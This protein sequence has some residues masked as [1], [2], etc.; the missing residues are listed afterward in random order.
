MDAANLNQDVRSSFIVY[1]KRSGKIVLIY[2]PVGDYSSEAVES[3]AIDR[4]A[5]QGHNVEHLAVLKV[6]G[7]FEGGEPQRVD[8][9]KNML[10]PDPR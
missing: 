5:W 8:V 1:E 2:S 6:E 10:V 4:A 3:D 9:E 7:A